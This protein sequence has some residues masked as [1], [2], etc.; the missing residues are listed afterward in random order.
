MPIFFVPPLYHP[1]MIR[2]AMCHQT[3]VDDI[4]IVTQTIYKGVMESKDGCV[5]IK[6]GEYDSKPVKLNW[7]TSEEVLTKAM[8]NVNKCGI[9][10]KLVMS[11]YIP[12]AP[13]GYLYIFATTNSKH[14]RLTSKT[15]QVNLF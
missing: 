6:V 9:A 5:L 14:P 7:E 13:G 10:T 3:Y 15:T 1:P 11:E 8:D 12:H 2:T 4:T